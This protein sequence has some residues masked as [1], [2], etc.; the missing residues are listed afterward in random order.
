M[1]LGSA[2]ANTIE[3]LDGLKEDDKV[4]LSDTAYIQNTEVE[5]WQAG[6]SFPSPLHQ[7]TDVLCAIEQSLLEESR[8]D[9]NPPSSMNARLSLVGAQHVGL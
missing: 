9:V 3:I 2:S 1:K 6:S 4:I 8:R 5:P 7:A